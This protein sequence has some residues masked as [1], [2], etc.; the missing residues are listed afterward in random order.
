MPTQW[1]AVPL[2]FPC[3]PCDLCKSIEKVDRRQVKIEWR[4][5]LKINFPYRQSNL[6][7]DCKSKGWIFFSVNIG[8]IAYYNTETKEIEHS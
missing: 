1:D 2:V 3:T 5:C 8:G 7:D 6:C 4:G